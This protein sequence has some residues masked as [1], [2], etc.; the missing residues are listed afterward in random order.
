MF[1]KRKFRT[2]SVYLADIIYRMLEFRDG[3]QKPEALSTHPLHDEA[4]HSKAEKGLPLIRA[5]REPR[6]QYKPN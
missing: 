1:H 3:G 4:C 5:M 2:N 6:P